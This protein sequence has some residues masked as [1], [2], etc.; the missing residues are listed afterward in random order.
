[1][2]RPAINTQGLPASIVARV[3]QKAA[4]E[5]CYTTPDGRTFYVNRQTAQ[6]MQR[7]NGGTIS[8]PEGQTT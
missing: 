1:M 5:W 2:N 8:P 6:R 4:S 7:V 3:A